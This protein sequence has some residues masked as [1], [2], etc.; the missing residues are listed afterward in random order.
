MNS[1]S[2][3]GMMVAVYAHKEV[4]EA[5]RNYTETFVIASINDVFNI[6]ISEKPSISRPSARIYTARP[7]N[8]RS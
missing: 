8:S 6:V 4:L 7:L 3:D 1:L 2:K 5:I